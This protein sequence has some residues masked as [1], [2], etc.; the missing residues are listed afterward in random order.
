MTVN[1]S[2][3]GCR[4]LINLSQYQCRSS[5]HLVRIPV[6][7]VCFD[8]GHISDLTQNVLFLHAFH[9]V[10]FTGTVIASKP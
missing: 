2:M 9:S 5:C 7:V 3:P 8:T 6:S 10:A 1:A 4:L